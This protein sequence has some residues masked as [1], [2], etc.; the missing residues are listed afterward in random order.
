MTLNSI[1]Q[2]QAIRHVVGSKAVP[3]RAAAAAP[4]YGRPANQDYADIDLPASARTSDFDLATIA[5]AG[6]I[7][8]FKLLMLSVLLVAF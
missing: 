2:N 8:L 3:L 6:S 1:M 7:I 5:I 4:P